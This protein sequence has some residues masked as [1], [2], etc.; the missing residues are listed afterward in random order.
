WTKLLAHSNP[1]L[2]L[3]ARNLAETAHSNLFLRLRARNLAE[4]AHS[5]PFLRLSARNP[6]ETAHSNPF[7]RLSAQVRYITTKKGKWLGPTTFLFY[8]ILVF[9]IYFLH[10]LKENTTPNRQGFSI[11]RKRRLLLSNSH[12]CC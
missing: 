1:F 7:L 4:T 10:V 5:N 2:R 6:A 11:Y 12:R 3:S 9:F 8:S